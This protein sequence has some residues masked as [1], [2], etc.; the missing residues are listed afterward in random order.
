MTALR[1]AGR[2][3][4]ALAPL[5]VRADRESERSAG[6]DAQAD[7]NRRLSRHGHLVWVQPA[8]RAS[9]IPS[10]SR[11]IGF[12][13][14]CAICGDG[15]RIQKHR[16][17]RR[18]RWPPR[19]ACAS[20]NAAQRPKLDL[21]RA[22]RRQ[23]PHRLPVEKWSEGP[24]GPGFGYE[25]LL[26]QQYFWAGQTSEGNAKFGARDCIIVKSTPGRI[27]SHPLRTGEDL[28]RSQTLI[29]RFTWR[30]PSKNP[31]R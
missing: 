14:Y 23:I 20:R 30:R 17:T 25:D 12:P 6:V 7:R 18:R 3:I 4:A 15:R 28:A 22:S 26:E 24:L 21:D 29:S 31:A 13:A 2:V 5:L 10:P 1:A 11:R 9:A 27:R 8:E 19:D 16:G